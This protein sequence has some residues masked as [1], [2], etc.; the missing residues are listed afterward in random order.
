MQRHNGVHNGQSQPI[1]TAAFAAGGVGA[2]KAVKE[3]IAFLS[4]NRRTDAI[5]MYPRI[6]PCLL[7]LHAYRRIFIAIANGIGDKIAQRPLEKH[8]VSVQCCSAVTHPWVTDQLHPPL[9]SQPLKESTTRCISDA[10]ASGVIL[11]T[12][13]ACDARAKNRIFSTMREM[14]SSSSILLASRV[15]Y[16]S[17]VRG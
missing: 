13:W 15:S 5:N 4:R 6:R 12:E 2:V 7:D 11:S 16:S 1:R 9:F 14:R 3:F 10:N 17:V 8:R